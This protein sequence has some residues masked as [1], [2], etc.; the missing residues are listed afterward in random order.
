MSTTLKTPQVL[1]TEGKIETKEVSKKMDASPVTKNK[2][3]NEVADLK[4]RL[5]QAQTQLLKNGELVK[6][7]KAILSLVMKFKT[8]VGFPE[9]FTWLWAVTNVKPILQLLKDIVFVLKT[10]ST[11]LAA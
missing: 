8:T 4:N 11:E 9:K 3:V 7:Y 1:K 6:D 5:E 10:K 2:V